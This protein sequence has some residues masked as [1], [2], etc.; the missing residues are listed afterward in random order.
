MSLEVDSACGGDT[1][2]NVVHK[3]SA[4]DTDTAVLWCAATLLVLFWPQQA[5]SSH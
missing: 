2:L 3:Q 1:T 5:P 4:M